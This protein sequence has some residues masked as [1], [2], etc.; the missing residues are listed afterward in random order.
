M[1]RPT[2]RARESGDYLHLFD[3]SPLDHSA[4]NYRELVTL[5]VLHAIKETILGFAE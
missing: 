4:N 3:L 2:H 1:Y 5:V